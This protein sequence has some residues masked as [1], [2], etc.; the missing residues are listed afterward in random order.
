MYPAGT[1]P[2]VPAGI[3]A[4]YLKPPGIDIDVPGDLG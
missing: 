3:E 2:D 1:G 4:N